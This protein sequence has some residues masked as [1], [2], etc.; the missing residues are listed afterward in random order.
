MLLLHRV[1]VTQSGNIQTD[2]LTVIQW[3]VISIIQAVYGPH[4]S[5]SGGTSRINVC[6]QTV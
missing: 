3:D 5:F 1:Y 6:T 2:L 4:G